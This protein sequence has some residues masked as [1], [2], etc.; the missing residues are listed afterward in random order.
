[1]SAI[2]PDMVPENDPRLRAAAELFQKLEASSRYGKREVVVDSLRSDYVPEPPL[3]GNRAARR[4]E[5]VLREAARRE[6]ARRRRKP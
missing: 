6:A 3:T 4:K 5:A 1:M 2:T